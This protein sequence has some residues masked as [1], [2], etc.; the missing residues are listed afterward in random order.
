MQSIFNVTI[1]RSSQYISAIFVTQTHS[2]ASR[3]AAGGDMQDQLVI[4]SKTF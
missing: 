2:A 4:E 1:S 3:R